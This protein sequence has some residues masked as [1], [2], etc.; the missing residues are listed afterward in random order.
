MTYTQKEKL[1]G[2]V[3]IAIDKMIDLQGAG[4]GNETIQRILDLL[5]HLNNEIERIA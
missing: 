4:I 1:H 2:K 3:N 5:N